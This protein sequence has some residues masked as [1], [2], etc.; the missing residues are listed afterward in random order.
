MEW[1]HRERVLKPVLSDS[2]RALLRAQSGP[3]AEMSFCP[4]SL[5]VHRPGSNHSCF[6]CCCSV[7][8]VSFCP[9]LRVCAEVA[10][11]L[12]PLAIIVHLALKPGFGKTG[13]RRGVLRAHLSR[14]RRESRHKRVRARPR[15]P[16]S[17]EWRPPFGGC[18]GTASLRSVEHNWRWTPL[19]YRRCTVMGRHAEGC[20]LVRKSARTQRLTNSCLRS[21]TE[22]QEG[23]GV[24]KKWESGWGCREEKHSP[25]VVRSTP[26]IEDSSQRRIFRTPNA[27][28]CFAKVDGMDF[29]ELIQKSSDYVRWPCQWS[30]NEESFGVE[31]KS[32]NTEIHFTIAVHARSHVLWTIQ[33]NLVPRIESTCNNS[34][35]T[36]IIWAV[37]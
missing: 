36:F 14:G 31:R 9:L 4:Q 3:A 8:C 26:Y 13:L 25:V 6:G 32:W 7:D 28:F 10:V 23:S 37:W 24:N 22:K 12:T 19:W 18:G 16:S 20:W 30:R 2:E 21:V 33:E 34:E 15:P 29:F 1:Q 5:R 17:R 35:F 11:S 27:S